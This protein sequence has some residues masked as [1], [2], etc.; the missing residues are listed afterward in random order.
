MRIKGR[1]ANRRLKVVM[2]SY[3]AT[4]TPQK[5]IL[6]DLNRELGGNFLRQKPMR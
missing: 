3:V 4:P 2:F 6:H 1:V 5:L